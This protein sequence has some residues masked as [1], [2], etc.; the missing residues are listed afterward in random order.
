MVLQ[1]AIFVTVNYRDSK[2]WSWQLDLHRLTYYINI[3]MNTSHK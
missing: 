3:A 1:S 2:H